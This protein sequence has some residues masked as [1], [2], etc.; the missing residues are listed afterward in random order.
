MFS[1]AAWCV[2]YGKLDFTV[3]G[4]LCIMQVNYRG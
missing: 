3:T 1:R 4:A 2:Y